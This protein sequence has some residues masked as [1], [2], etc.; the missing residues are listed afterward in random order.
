MN[1]ER[2]CLQLRPSS[3]KRILAVSQHYWPEPFPFDEMCEA[4]AEKG[5]EVDV[6]TDVPNYP[7]GWIYPDYRH[8][9]RRKEV[10]GGVQIGRVFTIGRRKSLFFR[11]LN[12]YSFALSSVLYILGI[13]KEYDAV[14][15]CQSSPVMMAYAGLVYAGLHGKKT[16]LYCMDLWPASLQAGGIPPQSLLYRYYYHVSRFIYRRTDRILVTTGAYAEYLN[17]EFRIP[18]EKLRFVP[19]FSLSG[20]EVRTLPRTEEEF[21]FVCAGNLGKAQKAGIILETARVF[22]ERGIR[23]KGRHVRW[24]FIGDGTEKQLLEKT[25]EEMKLDN[26]VFHGKKEKEE[27]SFLLSFA[28]VCVLTLMKD[29]DIASVMPSRL[30]LFLAA[31]KPVLAAASGK[32]AEIIN[33]G[34][35]GICTEA[36]DAEGFLRAAIDIMDSDLVSMGENSRQMYHRHFGKNR[37]V[38]EIEETMEEIGGEIIWQLS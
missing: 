14:L 18:E 1:S 24:H 32:T 30:L 4:L 12:Y 3:G 29:P 17:R 11:F 5:H 35:C 9:K 15:I 10:R 26:V 27:L 31:G 2:K 21:N 7:E 37:F 25:A 34:H 8:R 22:Q 23:F 13:E 28:D 20:E 33:E 36:E 6:V 38:S 16:V 19:Q